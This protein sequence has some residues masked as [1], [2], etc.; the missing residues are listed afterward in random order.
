MKIRIH[1]CLIFLLFIPFSCGQGVI[2]EEHPVKRMV[3]IAPPGKKYHLAGCKELKM[4]N[5]KIELPAA[6]KMGYEPCMICHPL[7]QETS[8]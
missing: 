7:E 6:L 1:R 5:R 3:F 2:T 8:E 4:N